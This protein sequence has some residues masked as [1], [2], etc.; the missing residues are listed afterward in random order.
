MAQE[1]T[2]FR[3]KYLAH[4]LAKAIRQG[5]YG[6]GERMP[7]LRYVR[8]QYDVSLT[9]VVQAFQL[10]ADDGL[11]VA[12]ARSGYFVQPWQDTRAL[13]P[14]PSKPPAQPMQVN[15]GQ[16]AM[17]LV[18]EGKSP[19]L[20]RLGAAVPGADILPLRILSRN[21]AGV[22]R[23]HWQE[24]GHYET[25]NGALVLRRQLARLMRQAGCQAT[26]DDITVTN[27]CME[28]LTLAL[29]VVAKP[30]DTIALESPTYFGVLQI[31]ES[32]GMR[33]LEIAT[34]PT[35][36]IDVS[37]LEHAVAK[38]QIHACILMPSFSNPLGACMPEQHKQRV[39]KL[40]KQANIP[41]IENDV[42]GVLSY[43]QPRPKAAKAY[44]D[45]GNVIYCSS[46]SKTMAP[47]YRVGWLLAGKYREQIEYCKFLDNIS[48]AT[49]PQLVLAEFIAKGSYRRA[50]QNMVGVYRRR[51]EQ[52]RNHV[53][54][55]FPDGTRI[56][57]PQGG[58][59]LWVELPNRL[60]CMLFYRKA[61]EK[62]IAISPGILFCANG[63]Y[64]NHIRISCGVLDGEKLHA[65][66][67]TLGELAKGLM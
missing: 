10:L 21:M 55:Y 67:K 19:R 30:N 49:L 62:N 60:D 4:D 31:I 51:M 23:R 53:S 47:G 50:L 36:G 13:E 9:T 37:A 39:V 33:A 32:L 61:M 27:G 14:N 22:A 42:Y 56:S 34:H 8:E 54:R 3:Y 26:P 41:L 20:I 11:L 28:A 24:A 6:I 43:T 58:F 59:L 35:L 1:K 57:N 48:T 45:T 18:A 16:L 44:D 17:S 66:L 12:R 25:P 15:V 40:F 65:A 29:R 5:V 46:F 7:S 38:N 52:L 2:E 64:R 63:Q